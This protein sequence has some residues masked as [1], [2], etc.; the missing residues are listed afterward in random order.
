[1]PKKPAIAQPRAVTPADSFVS[2][3]RETEA[4]PAA[5][6]KR[7]TITVS[8]NLHHKIKRSC[9]DRRINMADAIR[10]ALENTPWPLA[11]AA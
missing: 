6:M 2:A 11:E 8:E 7:I 4:A 3:P 5:P 1:M 10:E 9:V